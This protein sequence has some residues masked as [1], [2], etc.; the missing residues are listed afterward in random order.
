MSLTE[1]PRLRYLE[2]HPHED[3]GKNY[4]ILRDPAQ[5]SDRML[6]VTPEF[7]NLLPLFDGRHSLLDI[8]AE[9]SK[10]FGRIF[11][12][13]ELREIIDR[14]DEVHFLESDGFRE[15]FARLKGDFASAKIRPPHHAGAAYPSEAADLFDAVSA[16]YLHPDGAG[17]PQPHGGP[18]VRALIAPHIDLRSGGPTYTPAY[19]AL[20]EGPAPD[21]FV[22]MGTGHMGLPQMFSISP[23]DFQTPLGISAADTEF[24]EALKA[25][26]AEPLFGEDLSHRHEHTIE[27]QLVFLHHLFRL[28]PPRILP[29]LC[30]FSYA[31]LQPGSK[32]PHRQWF[33]RF[34]E[35][36]ETV[37][38]RSGR[39]IC[40]VASV[41]F[42]HMG[43]RYGD[44]FTPDQATIDD[45]KRKD[46]EMLESILSPDA[47]AFFKY[48]A[49]ER[50]QRR[51]CGFPA[52]YT[53]LHLLDGQKGRLLS[54]NHTVMDQTGSFVTYASAVFE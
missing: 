19:R 23:K 52:L 11:F 17:A 46:R 1:Y 13:E 20:A 18:A 41:D 5:I 2:T 51:I 3:Q 27:F 53:M 38:R 6:V 32:S 34:V 7:L 36:F 42:A 8:Q 44:S 40:F 26:L 28:A 49:S 24:L 50:D 43:P 12:N 39:R 22:I 47:D 21:L 35:T 30:S 14:L 15:Y 37:H 29:I 33:N 10:R 54:H 9:L 45:V 48:I 16:F 25:E 4:V 31:D